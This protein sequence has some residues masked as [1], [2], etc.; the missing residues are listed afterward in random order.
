[1]VNPASSKS[2]KKVAI[3]TK[4]YHDEDD[5]LEDMDEIPL[6]QQ[7]M[8]SSDAGCANTLLTTLFATYSC[9]RL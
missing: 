1:M 6:S 2:Q 3:Q 5:Q 8:T 9:V 7:S 4:S